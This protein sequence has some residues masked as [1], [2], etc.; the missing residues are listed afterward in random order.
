[1]D[2][3]TTDR[4]GWVEDQDYYHINRIVDWSPHGPL[5]VSDEI[6]VGGS[7]NPY[8]RFYETQGKTYPVTQN[9]GSVVHIPGITYLKHVLS[10]A[11]NSPNLAQIAVDL[12]THLAGHVGELAFEDVRRREFPH[13]PSRQRCVWL[14]PNQDG[15]RY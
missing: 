15:V 10:G 11:V 3:S 7:S 5:R 2:T 9:D 6:D 4:T 8:F 1:M 14:I 13:L 12:A